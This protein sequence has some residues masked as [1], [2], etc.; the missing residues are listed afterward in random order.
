MQRDSVHCVDGADAVVRMAGLLGQYGFDARQ[1]ADFVDG[2]RE[3]L[4]ERASYAVYAQTRVDHAVALEI[5]P[6]LPVHRLWL[7]VEDGAGC[8]QTAPPPTAFDRSAPH[9]MEW[10]VVLRGL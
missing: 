5:A 4:P 2:W 6:A 3:D 10:G 7:L 1:Q 8:V 9:G